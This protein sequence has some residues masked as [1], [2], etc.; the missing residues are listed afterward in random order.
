MV[1]ERRRPGQARSDNGIRFA[2]E[3]C[4]PRVHRL[5]SSTSRAFGEKRTYLHVSSW[6]NERKNESDEILERVVIVLDGHRARPTGTQPSASLT[7]HSLGDA[8]GYAASC[9]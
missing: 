1:A 5:S 7:S 6:A 4:A 9:R 8:E 2:A 3:R